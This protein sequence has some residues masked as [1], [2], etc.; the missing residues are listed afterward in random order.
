MIE[1]G[2][3]AI[4][5]FAPFHL[6]VPQHVIVENAQLTHSLGVLTH[7]LAEKIKI[8]SGE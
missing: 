7:K 4:W 5:N 2:V 1:A 8:N 6:K 3:M